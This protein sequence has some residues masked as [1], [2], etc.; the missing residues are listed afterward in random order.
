MGIG[1]IALKHRDVEVAS[2][3]C[4]KSSDPF[5]SLHCLRTRR[6]SKTMMTLLSR[7]LASINPHWVWIGLFWVILAS[8]AIRHIG[9]S[10]LECFCWNC[11]HIFPYHHCPQLL[12]VHAV[13]R[14]PNEVR[15]ILYPCIVLCNFC[16]SDIAPTRVV[17]RRVITTLSSVLTTLSANRSSPCGLNMLKSSVWGSLQLIM[18]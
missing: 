18:S 17:S 13:Y 5:S 15:P 14:A 11:L 2:G 9:N 12:A 7:Y 3:K 6:K 4:A 1:R 10:K 8:A 16:L